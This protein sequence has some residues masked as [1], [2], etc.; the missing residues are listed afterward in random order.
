MCSAGRENLVF[1]PLML[2]VVAAV[3]R[4]LYLSVVNCCCH[5]FQQLLLDVVSGTLLLSVVSC[6]F[7]SVNYK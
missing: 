2:Y 7:L 1:Q 4:T 6:C 5:C 3:S